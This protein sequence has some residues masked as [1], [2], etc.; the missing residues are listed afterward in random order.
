MRRGHSPLQLNEEQMQF[1]YRD[2]G[3][4]LHFGARGMV[5]VPLR[6]QHRAARGRCSA[7]PSC[8]GLHG[9]GRTGLWW[10]QLVSQTL[11][12]L[13]PGLQACSFSS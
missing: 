3:E 1:P 8:P 2:S 9:M 11:S 6:T 7:V 13:R 10:C 5:F 4:Q 12:S